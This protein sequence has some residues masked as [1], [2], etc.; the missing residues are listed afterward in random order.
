MPP[1]SKRLTH[2]VLAAVL[3]GLPLA[4]PGVLSVSRFVP[5]DAAPVVRVASFSSYAVLGYAV[6][7]LGCLLL[8]LARVRRRHDRAG[9][10]GRARPGPHHVHLP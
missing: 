6:V 5:G 3:L 10:G 8:L 4:G 7:L 9:R 2:P 1:P